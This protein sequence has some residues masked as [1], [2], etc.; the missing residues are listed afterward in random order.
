V[1]KAGQLL[2]M[3]TPLNSKPMAS[4][5]QLEARIFM[6]QCAPAKAYLQRYAAHAQI[7]RNALYFAA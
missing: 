4:P 6:I 3:A 1:K 7:C 5:A 2:L